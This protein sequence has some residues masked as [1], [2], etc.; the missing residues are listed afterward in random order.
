MG[1]KLLVWHEIVCHSR[2]GSWE[3]RSSSTGALPS[4]AIG[5]GVQDRGYPRYSGSYAETDSSPLSPKTPSRSSKD[6]GLPTLGLSKSESQF[7][8]SRVSAMDNALAP[9]SQEAGLWKAVDT[10]QASKHDL[11]TRLQ[12]SED[13]VR[14]LEAILR[15]AATKA[16]TLRQS[17][18]WADSGA[19]SP[20]APAE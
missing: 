16:E 11:E 19:L 6:D 5:R 4:Q 8:S 20:S 3:P 15:S 17:A 14:E 13:R 18:V 2:A 10:L 1:K 9:T 12:S 7:G